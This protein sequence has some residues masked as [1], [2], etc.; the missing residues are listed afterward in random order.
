VA[1]LVWSPA[2]LGDLA[3]VCEYICRDSDHYAKLFAQR[4]FSAVDTLAHT[5][6]KPSRFEVWVQA[7]NTS[8]VQSPW[9]APLLATISESGGDDKSGRLLPAGV[10]FVRLRAE[11]A[12]HRSK[13]VLT[14]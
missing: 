10:Y 6:N 13:V 3:A 9:D 7:K 11:G 1:Q 5:W 8:G 14:R 12:E 2:A 4:I